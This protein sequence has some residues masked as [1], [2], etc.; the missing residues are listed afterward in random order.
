MTEHLGSG[1]AACTSTLAEPGAVGAQAREFLGYEACQA[2]RIVLIALQHRRQRRACGFNV[3]GTGRLGWRVQPPCEGHH[4]D[5]SHR[6]ARSSEGE[7]VGRLVLYGRLRYVADGHARGHQDCGAGCRWAQ[8]RTDTQASRTSQPEHQQNQQQQRRFHR[9]LEH[10][11][12]RRPIHQAA[13]RHDP[14]R[15]SLHGRHRGSQD[16]GV[17][18]LR[19]PGGDE[20]AA[21]DKAR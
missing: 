8:L 4:R 17:D 12:H 7:H 9:V 19:L 20:G 18:V 2:L 10:V 13:V 11:A 16:H 1:A 21:G 15:N 5:P 3:T 6:E 14:G